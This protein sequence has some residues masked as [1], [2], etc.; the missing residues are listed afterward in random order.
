MNESY[1][2]DALQRYR[3]EDTES[4]YLIIENEDSLTEEAVKAAEDALLERGIG[5]AD[6]ESNEYNQSEGF[7]AEALKA[8]ED[9]FLDRG[10]DIDEGESN[11]Y[12]QSE[13]FELAA[14]S[15][16][17][18]SIAK[19]SILHRFF[20]P[21]N[22]LH[23]Y[24]HTA[25]K[26]KQKLG[27]GG[28]ILLVFVGFF[29]L[30]LVMAAFNDDKSP[31]RNMNLHSSS[32]DGSVRCIKAYL[33]DTYLSDP[34]SYKSYKWSAVQENGDGTYSVTHEYGAKN[35]FGAMRRETKKF[36]YSASGRVIAADPAYFRD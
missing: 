24:S 11:E 9:L 5:V 26:E 16:N 15:E 12:N 27:C 18:Q 3:S 13:G 25:P 14:D 34:D 30:F 32:W 1:Y 33:N 28:T 35:G 36:T 10:L 19:I 23:A 21:L 7:T 22:P 20:P 4:L 2:R 17:Y 31:K 29:L 6:G 8:A